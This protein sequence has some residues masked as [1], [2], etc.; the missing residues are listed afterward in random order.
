MVRPCCRFKTSHVPAHVRSRSDGQ[1]KKNTLNKPNIQAKNTRAATHRDP[2]RKEA[3]D[4]CYTTGNLSEKRLLT[5]ATQQ[6]TYQKRGFGWLLHN[7]EPIRKEAS[8]G[9][10]ASLQTN[11]CRV[12]LQHSTP[13]DSTPKH[14]RTAHHAPSPHTPNHHATQNHTTPHHTTLQQ[15]TTQTA[16]AQR[17]D[18]SPELGLL[19]LDSLA[20]KKLL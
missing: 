7:R 9:C 13:H 18:V 15:Y 6:G 4:G 10:Y 5:A 19:L 20:H 3:S 11:Q 16:R 8:D 14:Y 12:E 17:L 1:Q 2:I